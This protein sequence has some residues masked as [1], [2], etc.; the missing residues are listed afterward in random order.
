[1]VVSV[2]AFGDPSFPPPTESGY[3]SRRHP[4]L[5]LP[6]TIE[7]QAD[8]LWEPARPLYEAARSAEAAA[9]GRQLLEAHPQYRRLA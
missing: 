6:A 1:V 7:R 4:W 9:R 3:D 8:E 5:A 2:G